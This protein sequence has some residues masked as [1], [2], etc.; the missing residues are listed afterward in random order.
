MNRGKGRGR[1]KKNT[2]IVN[3]SSNIQVP[4]PIF[5]QMNKAHSYDIDMLP[6]R[7]ELHLSK[8]MGLSNNNAQ[9]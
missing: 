2:L 6:A 1:P 3:G 4:E 8:E 9:N 7:K 5:P